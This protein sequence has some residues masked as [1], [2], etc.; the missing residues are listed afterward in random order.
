MTTRLLATTSFAALALAVTGVA[1][2]QTAP[3]PK[4][5]LPGGALT[6]PQIG[7]PAPAFSLTTI[8]G[9][10]VTLD[11][12]RGKTLVLNIWATWCPPCRGETSDL[13]AAYARLHKDGVEFLG[14]DDTEQAPIVRAFVADK[15]VPYPQAI[16]G[17]QA[18]SKA[19]DIRYFPTTFVID[20][21][22]IVRARHIDQVTPALRVVRSVGEGGPERR[23]HVAAAGQ[24]RRAVCQ[25]RRLVHG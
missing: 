22:G 8:D 23:V 19:Y 15:N 4:P 3:T 7:Q 5:V 24:D 20:P 6:G 9:K 2:A 12:H 18:F 1:Q 16:D 25:P 14:V 13:L 17:T 11:S 21:Q 10:T